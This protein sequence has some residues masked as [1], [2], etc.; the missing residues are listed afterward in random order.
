[1]KSFLQNVIVEFSCYLNIIGILVIALI[2]TLSKKHKEQPHFSFF[3]LFSFTWSVALWL[4]LYVFKDYQYARI[5]QKIIEYSSSLIVFFWIKFIL[6]YFQ[7]KNKLIS[8]TN[9]LTISIL[10]ILSLFIPISISN[11]P[12]LFFNYYANIG[13][14]FP[15]YFSYI[16]F[17]LTFGHAL[18]LKKIIKKEYSNLN[19]KNLLISFFLAF[20][21]YALG[22][23][24]NWFLWFNIPIPPIG[25]GTLFV[26][27]LITFYLITK[28]EIMDIR[29]AI[30]RT[31]AYI[32]SSVM[33]VASISITYIA[34]L[35]YSPFELFGV[36][37]V[38]GFWSFCFLPFT[39]FLITSAKRKF[40]KGYYEPSK[41]FLSVSDMLINE[42]NREQI[43][44]KVLD[45]LDEALELE[46]STFIIAK[47]DSNDKLIG[48]QL[49]SNNYQDLEEISKDNILITYFQTNQSIHN[50]EELNE[51]L[52]HFLS[53]ELNYHKNSIL[54]P[55]HSPELLE[56]V[57]ILGK[58]SSG[59]FYSKEDINLLKQIRAILTSAFYKLT[60]YEKIEKNFLNT[61]KQLYDAERNLA[62]T[63]RIASLAHII[64]EY[65]HE[66]KTPLALIVM[67][68]EKLSEKIDEPELFKRLDKYTSRIGDIVRTT[69]RL[70]SVQK[71][72]QAMFNVNTTIKNSLNM[73]NFQNIQIHKQ[74]E[75]IPETMG[76]QDD[77]QML[78]SNLFQNAKEAM[79][80]GGKLTIKTSSDEKS[81]IIT[82]ADTGCGIPEENKEKI[83]DPFF[84]THVTKGRGLGLSIVFRI[85]REHLGSIELKSEPHKGATFTIKLP[86]KS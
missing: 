54:L 47:R 1:M 53:S 13:P 18:I 84:S 79:P 37:I 67:E 26:Y 83:F 75:N 15:L 35:P 8:I 22:T 61:Q 51:N 30:T 3:I 69:L 65:N 85:V 2:L 58:K 43:F 66:I 49:L 82:I 21:L 60:P 40:I 32:I 76:H 29:I 7:I 74:L 34:L 9:Y 27:V 64:Q 19:E 41:V 55:L 86:I 20:I 42:A 36:M 73:L 31:I 4:V 33:F 68:H 71:E 56:G 12:K 17:F 72:K 39:D 81:I 23:S 10:L 25:N 6:N 48:Y 62:R 59:K 52:Q 44:H 63:E 45:V 16:I 57:L 14:L 80:N 28:H 5:S 24:S 78:F 50:T 11:S 38:A 46:E 77:M 70:S